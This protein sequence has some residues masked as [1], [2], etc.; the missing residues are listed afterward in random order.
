MKITRIRHLW[1]EPAEF[2]VDR[3]TG[4]GEYIFLH[5]LN[6][7][8]I[9]YKGEHIVTKPDSCII[10]SPDEPEWF[11]S[12]VPLVHNWMHLTGDVARN[13]SRYGL[14]TNTIYCVGDGDFITE[15]L[16]ELEMEYNSDKK[17]YDSLSDLKLQEL[18][19]KIA[20]NTDSN[21]AAGIN[22]EIVQRFHTLRNDIFSSLERDWSVPE[23]AQR[24]FLSEPYFYSLY[25]R[26]YGI[27]PTQDIILARV[28]KAKRLLQKDFKVSE[29]ATMTGY[30]TEYHFINQFRK[31][32]GI[33]P[34][35]YAASL[36]SD[37]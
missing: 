8:E 28:D 13:L 17:F 36:K 26:I 10:Y 35:K 22:P 6:S 31:I 2:S 15:I 24:V 23:M 19:I 14:S 18:F 21:A 33:S 27:T 7:V 1:P 5:F 37:N 29:V 11:C 20:R 32:E 34:G 9:S 3:P 16:R 4:A 25:K 30:S 12:H